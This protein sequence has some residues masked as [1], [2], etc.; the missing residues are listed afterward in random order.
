MTVRLTLHVEG[1]TPTNLV[2]CTFIFVLRKKIDS[3]LTASQVQPFNLFQLFLNFQYDTK[4]WSLQYHANS[5]QPTAAIVLDLIPLG[6][7][8]MLC[9]NLSLL[10]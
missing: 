5:V 3:E 4:V 6:L 10:L 2:S 7:I 1:T 9:Y 8:D